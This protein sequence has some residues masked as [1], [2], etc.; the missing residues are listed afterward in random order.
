MKMILL[1]PP[2]AG[3]GTQAEIICKKYGYAHI[4]TGDILR[5]EIAKGSELGLKAKSFMDAGAL[6]PDEVVVG[7]V[8]ERLKADDCKE[9][10]LFD[11]FPR[12]IPQAE[13]LKAQVDIDLVVLIDVPDEEL[14]DRVVGRRTCGACG[15]IFHTSL[16][17]DTDTCPTCGGALKRRA[18][19]N[20][21][22][23][24]NR[25]D[26]YHKQTAPLEAFYKDLGILKAVDGT[27]GIDNVSDA[28]SALM[29]GK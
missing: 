11:G 8:V 14:V 12:T 29:E 6:V 4:S 10:C 18:D 13:A 23:V 1:G 17:G 22:T 16:I 19:D 9:G 24:K 25:L 7:I 27:T 2:G 3:K 28:I 15:E 20:A 21:E 5:A 26:A